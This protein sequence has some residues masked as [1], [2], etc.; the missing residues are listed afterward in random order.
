MSDAFAAPGPL[1]S[2]AR[3]RRLWAW[4]LAV[5][6]AI[7]STLSLARKLVDALGDS[8]AL[9][10]QLFFLCLFLVVATAVTQGL[11]VRPSGVE[12]GVA[13]GILT[14]Y[15][16]AFARMAM[17]AERSHLIEYGVVAVF[18]FEAITERASNGR[19]APVP[20]LLAIAATSLLGAL[21]E[22]IQA[23]LPSR[24]FALV[25]IL[26]NVLAGVMAVAAS[27][28]LGW[29]RRRAQRVLNT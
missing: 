25:D 23:F 1:F 14:V 15:V 20:A 9:G 28:A 3:E 11:K 4:T 24:V 29:A 6:V 18:I 27:I 5:V 19:R 7:Y 21:D 13:L 16:L 12:I 26:F 8:G 2:S 17:P 22:G 10:G